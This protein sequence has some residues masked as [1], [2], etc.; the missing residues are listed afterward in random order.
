MGEQLPWSAYA[1]A[2]TPGRV[3]GSYSLS[4]SL[5][6][7]DRAERTGSST[8]PRK[9]AAWPS[10]PEDKIGYFS[11][12][13]VPDIRPSQ[14]SC[15]ELFSP[16]KSGQQFCLKSQVSGLTKTELTPSIPFCSSNKNI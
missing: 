3:P 8:G 4:P 6:P 11:Q 7:H 5:R 2:Q 15:P 12:E 10:E 13:A 14:I 1:Y 9:N 16:L